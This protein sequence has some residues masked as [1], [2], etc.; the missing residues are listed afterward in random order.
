[1]NNAGIEQNRKKKSH[2]LLWW[3]VD[4]NA[5]QEEA[6][7][8][9]SIKFLDS[10]RGHSVICMSI[11][12]VVTLTLIIF[13]TVKLDGLTDVVLFLLF[14]YF[15]YKGHLWAILGVM[16]YWTFAKLYLIVS[17]GAVVLQ[18][19]GSNEWPIIMQAVW[20]SIYMHFFYSALLV[21]I[22]RKKLK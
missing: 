7:N 17:L 1:M 19:N 9:H 4:K 8:Y 12:I 22:K 20:W 15:V 5:I 6:D 10:S 3:L 14:S 11:A 21:E 18:Q 2:W 16:I 13:G